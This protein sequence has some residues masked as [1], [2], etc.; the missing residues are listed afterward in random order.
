MK[1]IP[2]SPDNFLGDSLTQGMGSVPRGLRTLWR[3][4]KSGWAFFIPGMAIRS[5]SRRDH[6]L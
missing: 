1:P 5:R 4:Q 6:P 2:S 3:C